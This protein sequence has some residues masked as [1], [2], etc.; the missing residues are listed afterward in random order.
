MVF[1]KTKGEIMEKWMVL[2][3]VAG[4][5]GSLS[6]KELPLTPENWIS[7]PL[8]TR[9]QDNGLRFSGSNQ[10]AMVRSTLPRAKRVCVTASFQVGKVVGDGHWSVAGV[11]ILDDSQN[12]WHVALVKAPSEHGGWNGYE[13]IE[14]RNGKW[15]SQT[16]LKE[17]FVTRGRPWREG[18][19]Y[20]FMLELDPEGITGTIRSETNETLFRQRYLFTAAAVTQGAPALHLTGGFHG[21]FSDTVADFSDPL[22]DAKK[23]IVPYQSDSFVS[24][25]SGEKTG[26][27]HLQQNPDGRWWVI[28]PLGRGT[29]LLGVDH[30]TFWGHWCE[31]LGYN[32]H[33]KKNEKKYAS[34][35]QWEEETLAR[36]KGWGFNFLGAGC[37]PALQHRG[38]IHTVFLSFGDTL[39]YSDEEYYITPN[40]QRPCSGFPNVFHPDFVAS[41]KYLARIHCA[42]NK[43]DP[44]LFGY[45]I[46]N[47]L[48]WWGRGKLN[49]GLFATV[50]KKAATHTAK[51]SLR[52][53]LAEKAGNSVNRFNAIWKTDI[54][55][56]DE[57]LNM[58]TLPEDSKEQVTIKEDF[59]RLAAE[60]Y[61]SI[62]AAA[63]READPNHLV[64]GAR[65]AGTGGAHP[66][67]WEVSGKYCDLVTFNCYP[68]ADL[69][70]N[71][72]FVDRAANAERVI[73]HFAKYYDYVKR[74]MLVTEW[75]FPALDSGLPCCHGAG[76]RF[77]TQRERTAATSLFARTMLSLPFLVG[78]D[79]FMWVDEPALGISTPFPEDS[80]YGLIN[81]DGEPY[82]LLTEMFTGLQKN[83]GEMRMRPAPES[84]AVTAKPCPSPEE[85]LAKLGKPASN[86]K[87]QFVR[88]GNAYTLTTPAQLALRGEIGHYQMVDEITWKGK[89][90]SAYNAMICRKG[91][92]WLDATRLTAVA[93]EERDGR[94]VL[95]LTSRREDAAK[96]EIVHRLTVF[97]DRPVILCELVR[98]T[99]LD[100]TPLQLGSIY[101]RLY[102]AMKE[103]P[104]SEV[105]NLWK[106]TSRACW[107]DSKDGRYIGF[108]AP[109]Q[110]AGQFYFWVDEG[111]GAHPDTWFT[112][113]DSFT[114]PKQGEYRPDKPVYVFCL[115]GDDGIEKWNAMT[116]ALARQLD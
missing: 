107:M 81:E 108:C 20:R 70:A 21:V 35:A 88:D 5:L 90:L 80:N 64:M 61:F 95:T 40:E 6:A 55:S 101:F 86:V 63:I 43:D 14:M 94:G 47:E 33:L 23:P 62:S 53:F 115:F 7:D 109:M 113:P 87:C 75:S 105:P 99:N 17:A 93:Y 11:A 57:I 28:D 74:P 4:M 56:F 38:L 84:R 51:I 45:F 42:P 66:I 39:A 60:R 50:L 24:S 36:L 19:T 65:F 46:D 52:N 25:V 111:G 27:F 10:N 96:F 3:T 103:T 44:W 32:P 22:P 67:V 72:V 15:L 97:P 69:D 100:E 49:T 110:S 116:D 31:K 73:D 58:T 29:V 104:K 8:R 76:Q 83:I 98:V 82:A 106:G 1:Q 71:T 78:Y 59:L 9:F 68:W 18:E 34:K 13:L 112:F 2:I 77:R 30:V 37:D 89:P 16:E 26:F 102:S 12:F 41:C 79:Y 91:P 54:R 48:A 114:I 85:C 92:E